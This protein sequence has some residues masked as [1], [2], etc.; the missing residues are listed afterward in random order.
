MTA[1]QTYGNSASALTDVVNS[2]KGERSTP[3]E[4]HTPQVHFSQHGHTLHNLRSFAVKKETLGHWFL[5]KQ[6]I[7]LVDNFD[8]K[9]KRK[10]TGKTTP[11][12]QLK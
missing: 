7:R 4:T 12:Y 9:H 2:L 1:F 10:K 11:T 5:F 8:G 3:S 6:K